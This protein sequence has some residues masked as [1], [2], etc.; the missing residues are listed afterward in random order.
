MLLTPSALDA[1]YV[2]F[3]ANFQLGVESAL[4]FWQELATEETSTTESENYHFLSR[5]PRVR[6]WL[7]DRVYND[8][9]AYSYSLKNEDHEDSVKI[10]RNKIEDDKIGIFSPAFKMMGMATALWPD[11]LVL[12][13]LLNGGTQ[14]C[15]DGQY[16]FDTDHL[17]DPNNA[18]S[19]T[20]SNLFTSSSLT[21]A[22]YATARAKMRA[23][24]GEDGKTM[25][26]KP[27]LLIVP[28][29]LEKTALEIVAPNNAQ[30][31]GSNTAAA[32][33]VNVFQGSAKVLVIDDLSAAAGGSDTTWYLAD[34]TKPIKPFVMQFRRKL[35]FIAFDK[36]T[37]KDVFEKREFKYGVDGRG[38]AGYG[39]WYLAAKCTA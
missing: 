2:G 26:V 25:R 9:A 24:I 32:A 13:A 21:Q 37:D 17:A 30:V 16:F 38:A 29:A 6:K 12:S 36:S 19:A 27:N 8:L 3:N 31:F 10:P 11:D 15:F 39:L 33:P 34:T 22:N 14:T 5:I 20:Q 23:F 1:A 28:P 35:E 18:S 7:G 4:P